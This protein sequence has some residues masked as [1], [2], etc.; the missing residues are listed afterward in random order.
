[1]A[2]T[3]TTSSPITW[4][5]SLYDRAHSFVYDAAT[6][7]VDILAPQAG[8]RVLDVGCGTGPLTAKLAAGGASVLGIDSSDT[9]VAA[10]RLAF[11][12]L[13]FS[14]ADV[15]T[16]R[17]PQ[18]FDAVF[19]NATL[20]WV[21]PPGDAVASIF[22]ALRPGGRFVAEFGGKGNVSAIR[23]AMETA[24]R[25]LN[26]DPTALSPWYFPS[27]GEYASLLEVHGFQVAT[28]TTFPR[29]NVLDG[30]AG[31]RNWITMFGGTYVNA[32]PSDQR[33]HFFAMAEEAARPR[34]FHD[35]AWHADYQ[36][37]RVVATSRR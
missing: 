22:T 3:P 26:V 25:S 5:A 1:M 33:D 16:F 8:E 6:D 19:S 21:R 31:L 11:P 10:A 12:K 36:R 24:L 13:T 29:L 7:L 32:V 37:L 27:V 9:M 30:P 14:V 15:R 18:P 17:D 2:D 35:G 34:L 28:I 20:H 4:D 23:A